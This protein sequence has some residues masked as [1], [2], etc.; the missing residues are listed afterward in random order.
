MTI[1]IGVDLHQKFCYMTA[2]NASGKKLRQAQVANDGSALRAWLRE[3]DGPRQVV[4]E[5]SGFWPAFARAV[6]GETE[7]LVMVHPQRVKAIAA[8]RLKNDR[9][10]SETLAHLSRADLLPEA[11]MADERTQQLRMLT[12]LRI[13]LGRQRARARNQLQAVLHQEGF[14]KP[15]ADVFGKRGRAWLQG[16]EL[17][18]AA[19]TVVDTWR[20][21]VDCLDGLIAERTREL[22]QLAKADVRARW[23]QSVPGIGAYSAMVILAEI[24]DIQRFGNKRALA[25]YAGLTPVVR[26]SAGKRKRGG[27]G[28]HGSQT[29]RWIMLQAAQVAARY[30]PA[31][32]DYYVRL[33]KRKPAQVAKIALAHKL[34]T[35]VWALL[36]HGVCFDESVFARG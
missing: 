8:A 22:E 15:V 16:I 17:S 21:E 27:I 7:R 26:E 25:S 35:A 36:R 34:L 3:L 29:L 19:R 4:V 5:A 6:G 2:V 13:T 11:W 10:D 32:K 31:A 33:R 18:A 28:H 23:L 1:H 14:L 30:C 12:R 20:G 24:G 9:V